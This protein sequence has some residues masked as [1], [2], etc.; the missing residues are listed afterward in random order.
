MLARRG[1]LKPS[2]KAASRMS[3]PAQSF[4]QSRRASS[5]LKASF[6]PDENAC[7]TVEERRFSAA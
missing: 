4:F 1:M 7:S 6:R 3:L 5:V 2:V